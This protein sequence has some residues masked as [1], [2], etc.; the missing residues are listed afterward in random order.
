MI[1]RNVIKRLQSYAINILVYDP[2]LTEE[3]AAEMHV[4]K[5]SLE[6]IFSTC[7]TVSNHVANLPETVGMYDYELFRLMKDNAVFINTGRGAQVVEEDLIRIL[8][9]KPDLTAVLDVTWPEPP[10][11][12]SRLY[13][14]Q[15]VFLTPHIAGSLGLESG[16][17]VNI[18]QGSS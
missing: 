9:E 12:E 4:R 18:W 11:Q 6:E 1:G 17:W 15:N 16:V 3:A 14:L 7:Q 5:A 2:F 8:E 10:V 13:T